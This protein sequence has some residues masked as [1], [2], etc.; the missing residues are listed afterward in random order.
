MFE[1]RQDMLDF[2]SS[3]NGV[4]LTG[5]MKLSTQICYRLASLLDSRVDS[6]GRYE[7]KLKNGNSF[8]AK[9]GRKQDADKLRGHCWDW[10][11]VGDVHWEVVDTTYDRIGKI[12]YFSEVEDFIF[13]RT[14]Q[15][16][17]AIR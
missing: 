16:E 11:I 1:T 9:S 2:L 5:R 17:V 15:L 4:V 12:I 6:T 10:A 3:G 13:D 14:E 7:I 8:G